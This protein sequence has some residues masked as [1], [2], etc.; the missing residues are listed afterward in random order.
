MFH[1][2]RYGAHIQT[3]WFLRISCRQ[4]YDKREHK[5][6]K[7]FNVIDSSGLI[8]TEPSTMV[9]KPAVNGEKQCDSLLQNQANPK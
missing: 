4:K 1:F 5:N 8:S 3:Q 9:A 7:Q 2:L 6:V